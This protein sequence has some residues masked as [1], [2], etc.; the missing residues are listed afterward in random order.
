MA[1]NVDTNENIEFKSVKAAARYFDCD[2]SKINLRIKNGSLLNNWKLMK[3][4]S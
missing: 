3:G 1:T 2:K 4:P